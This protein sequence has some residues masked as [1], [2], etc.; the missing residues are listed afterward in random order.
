MSEE[1]TKKI[2]PIKRRVP[3]KEL[4][5]YVDLQR[6]ASRCEVLGDDITSALQA[7]IERAGKIEVRISREAA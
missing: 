1:I 6:V 5:A 2:A 3:V 7:L 4:D